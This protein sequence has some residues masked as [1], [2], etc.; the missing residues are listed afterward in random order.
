MVYTF[1]DNVWHLRVI[2]KRRKTK[3]KILE[4]VFAK[5]QNHKSLVKL[6]VDQGHQIPIDVNIVV[7]RRTEHNGGETGTG[8]GERTR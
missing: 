7:G 2:N 5:T 3:N 1:M 6:E 8:Q 4:R